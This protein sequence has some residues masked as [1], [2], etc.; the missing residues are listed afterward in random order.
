MRVRVIVLV[1]LRMHIELKSTEIYAQGN[2]RGVGNDTF[3]SRVCDF[4]RVAHGRAR[5]VW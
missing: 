5:V 3:R 2:V 4:K 1:E